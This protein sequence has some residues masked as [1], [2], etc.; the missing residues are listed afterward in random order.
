MGTC[1]SSVSGSF[2]KPWLVSAWCSGG[3]AVDASLGRDLWG[4]APV[5]CCGDHT[6]SLSLEAA[7]TRRS[8]VAV[9]ARGV[10]RRSSSKLVQW[11]KKRAISS[12]SSWERLGVSK[13]QVVELLGHAGNGGILDSSCGSPRRLPSR[14]GDCAQAG[15]LFTRSFFHASC[16]A[17]RS[18]PR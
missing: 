16:A 3:V 6:W 17:D 5:I 1:T 10:E 7:P 2:A 18:I 13:G 8:G 4:L 14:S 11:L 9:G 15:G 12:S